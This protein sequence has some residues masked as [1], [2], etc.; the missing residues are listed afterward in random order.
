MAERTMLSAM[1][2]T[3]TV[4]PLTMSTAGLPQALR[5]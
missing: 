2:V 3:V 4:A 5:D 1:T